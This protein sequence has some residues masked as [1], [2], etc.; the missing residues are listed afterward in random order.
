MLDIRFLRE[1]P[2]VVRQNIKN[3]FQDS[4]L[5]LVDEVIALDLRNR[6]IKQEVEALRAEKNKVS[7]MKELAKN[8]LCYV[9]VDS[10]QIH[11]LV[12]IIEMIKFYKQ[13]IEKDIPAVSGSQ[14]IKRS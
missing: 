14:S 12:Q 2:D 13:E 7:K 4:K 11:N 6:E 3:K 8:S 9:S 1:N 5:P 10:I